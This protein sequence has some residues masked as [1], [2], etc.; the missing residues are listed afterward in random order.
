MSKGNQFFELKSP[1]DILEKVR[2]E[3][4]KLQADL[5]TDNVFN[6]VITVN[7]IR[8]Y[9][10]DYGIPKNQLP[11]GADIQL[12]RDLCNIAKHLESNYTYKDNKFSQE[13]VKLWAEGLWAKGLWDGKRSIF[14]FEGQQLNILE[15]AERVINRWDAILTK[16]GL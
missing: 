3:F 5:N 7:H 15:I 16:H 14:E 12:C 8:D 4:A 10:E 2:K 11:Y 9:A 1:R 6:F 13:S